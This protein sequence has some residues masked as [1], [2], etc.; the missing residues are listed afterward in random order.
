MSASL[1]GSEMCIRDRRSTSRPRSCRSTD[2]VGR[3][4]SGATKRAH[5]RLTRSCLLYTSDA[6]DD[7]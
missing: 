1:V 7:M 4:N 5:A 2:W 3:L 6:A